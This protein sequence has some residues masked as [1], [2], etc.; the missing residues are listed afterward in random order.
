M[1]RPVHA[2]FTHF[3]WL[4]F[5]LL[6]SV[7]PTHAQFITDDFEGNG[8][9]TGWFGDDCVLNTA[10]ANPHQQGI[11]TSATVLR[12][13]D[14]GGQY[15]NVRFDVPTNIDLSSQQ[16]FSLKIYV[17]SSG[18]TGTAPNQVSLKLQNGVLTTPWTSQCEIIKPLQLNQWQT[19]T[20]NFASD[21][22]INYNQNSPPP[23]QRADFNRVIIQV[24]GENN[25]FQVVAF[26][27]DFLFNGTPPTPSPYTQ[28]VWADEFNSNGAIDTSKW[29]HQTQLP[30]GG[31]WFNGE[32]QHYT[33]RTDNSFV[34]NGN[35]H[36]VAKKENFTAQGR[37]KT[38]TSARLNSKFAFTNG[39]VEVRAKLPTGVGTWPAI[40]TL[41]KN[42]NEAGAYWQTQGFGTTSWPACGEIDIMEHWG[43]NQNFVQS[44]MHTP[45]S[46]GNT[47]NKGG[48]T[49]PT[50]STA[51]HV[52]ELEWSPEKMV[53]SVDGRVHYTYNPPV[54]NASTW[55][56]NADQYLILNIAI[57]PIILP[58]F[59]QSSMEIDYVR[60][61]QLPNTTSLTELPGSTQLRVYPNPANEQLTIELPEQTSQKLR[62]R[63]FNA[64][65][66]LLRDEE[67]T[68]SDKAL[69]L[70]E[71]GGLPAGLYLLQLEADGRRYFARLVK[72]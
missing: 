7:A 63:L 37:T 20:F 41:G 8:N 4:L 65:G 52:Y 13:H 57:Q 48:Q 30:A 59:T 35:L 15:A 53:F 18:L 44:A 5:A 10:F 61:Y 36:I 71:L 25:N 47:V 51:F 23:I 42:I 67:Y 17:P 62:L 55:P 2:Y 64:Q 28:L 19:V 34:A 26:I 70:D 31:S 45:S 3:P 12:Y 1:S 24:N 32:I 46:S 60:V 9:I 39:R 66:Q 29:F 58:S 21:P 27:D 11:N 69:Q 50:A 14:T 49:I 72:E 16:T 22:Y 56:F 6:L 43:D 68:P 38:H 40:W 54:K 33:N